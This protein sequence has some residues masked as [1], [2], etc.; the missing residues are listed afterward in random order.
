MSISY[1]NVDQEIEK[2]VAAFC[3][4]HIYCNDVKFERCFDKEKQKM[5]ID[6]Y[7]TIPE[8]NIYNAPTDEKVGIHYVNNPIN[9]YLMELSLRLREVE[10]KLM[11]GSYRI[12]I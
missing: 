7:L 5:G 2:E 12:R 3:D 11:D 10:R 6:G 8:L 4:K 9:T 1:R